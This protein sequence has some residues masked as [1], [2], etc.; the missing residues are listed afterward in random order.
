MNKLLWALAIVSFS[1]LIVGNAVATQYTI[2]D[3]GTIGGVTSYAYGVNDS[4][5]VAGYAYTTPG[6]G[7]P[8][9]FTYA[10]GTTTDISALVV[11]SERQGHS[12]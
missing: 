12:H 4:G 10:N 9:A 3:M 8:H 1:V 7:S 5:E 6:T 2:T 11:H